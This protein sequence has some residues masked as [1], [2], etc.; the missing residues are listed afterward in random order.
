MKQ[1]V[2]AFA[3][4]ILC[5]T[6]LL[7]IV[8]YLD[9]NNTNHSVTLTN[10]QMIK[11][12]EESGY[13]VEDSPPNTTNSTEE[14]TQKLES[15]VDSMETNELKTEKE[16]VEPHENEDDLEE[17]ADKEK[18]THHTL[19]INTGMSSMTIADELFNIG[20]IQDTEE[21]NQFL[22]ENDYSTKIQIGEYQLSTDMT[23]K[24]I[25][26]TITKQ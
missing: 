2:Q 25:A 9:K 23:E 22:E 18:V 1:S 14:E 13:N 21:F 4:G 5:A 11:H 7:S 8:Y 10:Q 6:A 24:Q 15:S 20:L 19:V 17:E 12:L 26:D 16:E 3:L